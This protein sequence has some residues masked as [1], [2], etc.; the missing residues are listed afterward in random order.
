MV[1]PILIR[2]NDY[3]I[4]KKTKNY[5]DEKNDCGIKSATKPHQVFNFLRFRIDRSISF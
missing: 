5:K 1:R 3:T 2:N 4:I